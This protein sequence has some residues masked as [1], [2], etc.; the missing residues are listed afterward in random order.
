MIVLVCG[1]QK[2]G[3]NKHIYKKKQPHRLREGTCCYQAGRGEGRD[4]VGVWD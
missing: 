3:V 1:I 2:D 4:Q